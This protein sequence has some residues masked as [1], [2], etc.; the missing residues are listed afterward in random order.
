MTS[1]VS[2][3]H[4]ESLLISKFAGGGV[5]ENNLAETLQVTGAREFHGS[6]RARVASQMKYYN[7]CVSMGG[8]GDEYG[9][10]VANLQ[11]IKCLTTIAKHFY[12]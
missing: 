5:K 12:E 4:K 6:A 1:F 9:Y 2:D 7:S 11:T 10:M 3:D 8:S